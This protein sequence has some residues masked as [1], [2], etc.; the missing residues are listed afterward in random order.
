L[1]NLKG[2]DHFEDVGAD[3]KTELAWML[4]KQDGKMWAGCTWLRVGTSGSNE[5][6]GFIQSMEFVD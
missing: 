4:G 1:E 3:G 2:R 5:H 6:S